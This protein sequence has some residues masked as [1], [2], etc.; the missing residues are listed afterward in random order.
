MHYARLIATKKLTAGAAFAA[1]LAGSQVAFA[2]GAQIAPH[3]AVYDMSLISA[4]E[5]AGIRAARGR[6][7]VEIAA[8]DCEGWTVN[9]RF[10]NQ[11][12]MRRGNSSLL[13]IQNSSY[14]A[15]D[16]SLMQFFTREYVNSRLQLEAKGVARA[17]NSGGNVKMTKPKEESFSLPGNT[18]FPISHTVRLL[19]LARKG[20]QLDE[21]SLYE[22]SAEQKVFTANSA[23][24]KKKAGGERKFLKGGKHLEPLKSVNSWPV[25]VSY[26]DPAKKGEGEE[27]PSHQMSFALFDNGVTGDMTIDYGDFKMKGALTHLEMLDDPGCE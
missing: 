19:K 11:F 23:I 25:S 21:V 5:R 13:D 17:G 16:G 15:S 26:Y 22:G 7:A 2:A 14:E 12:T 20:E 3:R 24:G 1:L 8:T 6:L 4:E 27:T 9:V 18:A 10:V